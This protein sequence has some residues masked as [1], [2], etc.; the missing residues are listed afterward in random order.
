MKLHNIN[1]LHQ[2]VTYFFGVLSVYKQ[3]TIIKK[4]SCNM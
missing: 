4:N 2:N 3:E 1:N